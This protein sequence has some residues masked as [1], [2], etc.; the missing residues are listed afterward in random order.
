MRILVTGGA[1]YVGS[2]TVRHLQTAGHEPVVLD[3]LSTGHRWA[4]RDVPLVVGDVG[5]R[6][7][8]R[9]VVRDHD[10][11]A[12]IHFAASAYVRESI[13]EPRRYY[14]NNVANSLA[15]LDA[16][17]D[18]DVKHV[19]FSS[20][21]SV[22]GV[23]ETVPVPEDHPLE[24]ISP[25]GTGKAFVE[26]VLASYGRAYSLRWMALRYFNA[27]G[28]LPEDRL[29][30]AHDPEPHLI[31]RT[32]EA[33]LGGDEPLTIYG[34]D[35]PTP[36]GTPVRDY[37]HV[38]DL[39]RAHVDALDHLTE[40]GQAMA[41]NLGTGEGHSV[42]EV[43]SMVE[44]VSGRDVSVAAG[45]SRPGDPPNLVADADRAGDLLRWTPERSGL[46]SIIESAWIWHS[47]IRPV[48]AETS[49]TSEPHPGV[50]GGSP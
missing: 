18:E 26:R 40:G 20:S 47:E 19:V 16:L 8:V 12:A 14:G 34:T 43:I 7:R 15:F 31:P 22:Y 36:D 6:T 44:H 3:D 49:G 45:A 41:L 32:I 11:Q 13:D 50:E 39:A 10:L 38:G 46:Q 27:A 48:V 5:D 23:P 4:V 25:Y 2:A 42:R 37:V 1:G 30:E 35:H 28:A 9:K 33:A 29:G 21:C 24:P 17:L